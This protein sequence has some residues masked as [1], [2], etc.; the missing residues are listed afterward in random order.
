MFA[1]VEKEKDM[2]VNEKGFTLIEL[3]TT[4]GIIGL[5]V[6]IAAPAYKGYKERAY[7]VK[8][9]SAIKSGIVAAEAYN[10]EKDTYPLCLTKEECRDRLPGLPAFSDD[11]R[12]QV[13]GGTKFEGGT[14]VNMESCSSKGSKSSRTI[15]GT[16]RGRPYSATIAQSMTHYY[17]GGTD[18]YFNNS[19]RNYKIFS[20]ERG[21]KCRPN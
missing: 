13:F 19:E 11:I 3:I 17:A 14:Y 20:S 10:A 12:F 4:V 5:L 15:S 9:L 1:T 8:A 16:F 18:P 2:I 7:D 6:A 21:S